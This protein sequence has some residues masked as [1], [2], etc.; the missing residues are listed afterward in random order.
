EL[1]KT[2]SVNTALNRPIRVVMF[3]S[4]PQLNHDAKL[5]LCK[6]EEHPEIE[7][8][9]AF[10]QAD[11][12]SLTAVFAD[13]WRRRG[14]LALPL[15]TAWALNQ[16]FRFARHPHEEITLRRKLKKIEERM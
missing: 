11:A 3:G 16:V 1:F 12:Q 10:C 9:G 15:F 13:L 4:G 6:L 14:W 8:L 2:L 5:F 7:L